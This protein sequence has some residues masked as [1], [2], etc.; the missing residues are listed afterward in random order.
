L[1]IINSLGEQTQSII[2]GNEM[3]AY[4][5]WKLLKESFTKSKEQRKIVLTNKI[6]NL[7]FDNKDISIFIANLQNLFKE[8]SKIDSEISDSSKIGI[9]N[10]CLP[11][12]L[13]WINVFQFS[14]WNDRS[15]FVKRVI[16]EINLSNIKKSIISSNQINIVFNINKNKIKTSTKTKII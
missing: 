13:R 16:P 2:E 10:R 6:E 1:I 15:K 7:K 3:S 9:L 14:T 12:N 8:I 4:E 5:I 11:E